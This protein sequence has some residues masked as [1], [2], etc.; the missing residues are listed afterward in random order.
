MAFDFLPEMSSY[1]HV[2]IGCDWQFTQDFVGFPCT[3]RLAP[4]SLEVGLAFRKQP[5]RPLWV[6]SQ[7]KKSLRGSNQELVPVH[8]Y[9]VADGSP[10]AGAHRPPGARPGLKSIRRSRDFLRQQDVISEPRKD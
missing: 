1:G 9:P 6:S 3:P 8:L 7:L 2:S 10:A 5:C 4:P